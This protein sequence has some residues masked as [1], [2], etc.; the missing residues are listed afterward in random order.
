M[1]ETSK[2]F[3]FIILAFCILWLTIFVSWILYYVIRIF[4]NTSSVIGKAQN[5]V[6]KLDEFIESFKHK[7][8]K[9]TS[10]L[11]ILGELA[12]QG[13]SF[14]EKRKSYK[15]DKDIQDDT[16][17]DEPKKKRRIFKKKM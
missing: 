7:V 5:T 16:Q 12:K 8:E 17:E 10:G 15:E 2:D 3:L 11:L 14:M 4:K 13:M 6:E 1:L 9:S